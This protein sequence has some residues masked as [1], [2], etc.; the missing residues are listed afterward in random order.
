LA[1]AIIGTVIS[2]AIV[3]IGM[4]VT[5]FAGL[6]DRM[7]LSEAFMYGS[8]ISAVDPVATLAVFAHVGAP[9][10]LN[11]ILAGESILNDAVAI[12]LYRCVSSRACCGWYQLLAAG[13]YWLSAYVLLSTHRLC[14]AAARLRRLRI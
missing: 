11:S 14:C 6:S 4:I 13:S 9:D 10:Q 12:V 2:T 8:L 1:F 7:P 3:G 5:G